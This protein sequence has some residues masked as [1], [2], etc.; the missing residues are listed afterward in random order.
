MP[1][2]ITHFLFGKE[3]YE[4]Q[5]E[6]IG[7]DKDTFDAFI[8][9]NQGPDVFFFS[10]PNPRLSSVW[11]LGRMM[12]RSDPVKLI[13]AFVDAIRMLP[14]DLYPIGKSYIQGLICHFELDRSMHPF[15]YSQQ[16]AICDAG[17]D[18]LSRKDGSEVHTEIE[19]ELDI[20]CLST[21]QNTTI[22]SFDI[23][24]CALRMSPRTAKVISLLYKNIAFNLFGKTIPEDAFSVS[25]NNYKTL[26]SITRSP[27]GTKRAAFGFAERLFRNHSFLQAFSHQNK[28]IYE[29]DF[30]NRNH[31]KWVNPFTDEISTDSFWDIY[32][33][34]QNRALHVVPQLMDMNS[35][36]IE[37]IV[38]GVDFNGC[39]TDAVVVKIE[40]I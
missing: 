6:S 10:V 14:P 39:P 40:D 23:S 16:Y 25:L 31:E 21:K 13:E 37:S 18:G 9:G 2:V 7:E 28:L 36:Q 29:S 35:T 5:F 38:S 33:S 19:S 4:K 20:L 11:Y 17:I 26:L 27:T 1:A 34:A 32:K 12:H 3:I 24:S 8:V 22:S 15:V 30:D